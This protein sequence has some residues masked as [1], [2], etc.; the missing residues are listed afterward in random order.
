MKSEYM[1]AEKTEHKQ[2]VFFMTDICSPSYL[3]VYELFAK[4]DD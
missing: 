3:Q 2:Y 1:Q 4:K